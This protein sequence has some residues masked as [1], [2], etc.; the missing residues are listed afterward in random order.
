MEMLVTTSFSIAAAHKLTNEKE[1]IK[2]NVSLYGK[3]RNMHG[4]NYK[5]YVTVK[6]EKAESGMVINFVEMKKIIQE[7]VVEKYD[8]TILNNLMKSIPTA[9]NMC[10]EFWGLLEKE[11]AKLGLK[12]FEIKLYETENSCI[13]LRRENEGCS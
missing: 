13:T 1:S 7:K 11:F 9:E 10:I 5:L 8:H 6:G 2:K 3:C 4:H 12:L